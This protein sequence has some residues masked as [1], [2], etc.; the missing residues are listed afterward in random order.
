[1]YRTKEFIVIKQNCFLKISVYP[2]T[3][4]NKRVFDSIKTE[5]GS[6]DR[7]ITPGGRTLSYWGKIIRNKTEFIYFIINPDSQAIKIGKAKNVFKRLKDL[8]TGSPA[9]LKLLKIID[10][11]AGKEAREREEQF[12]QKF[13]HLRLIGEWF[14]YDG[15][16]QH[17]LQNN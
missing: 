8:Q 15:D 14:R 5:I 9:E 10:V 16:L 6:N 4:T 12:H 2:S 17:F 13:Q 7:I 11:R 3:V 1:M